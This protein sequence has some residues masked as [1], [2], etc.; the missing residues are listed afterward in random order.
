MLEFK[1]KKLMVL[2]QCRTIIHNLHGCMGCRPLTTLSISLS[3][4]PFLNSMLLPQFLLPPSLLT[5]LPFFLHPSSSLHPSLSSLHSSLPPSSL[6]HF[7]PH[8]LS[9]SIPPSPPSINSSLPPSLSSFPHFFPPSL[10][11]L[12]PSLILTS[13][14]PPSLPPSLPVGLWYSPRSVG[15]GCSSIYGHDRS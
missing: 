7:L 1:N 14:L 2:D 4:L 6:P 3:L 15:D 9:S 11:P 13:S 8:F 12:C 5:S 10:P